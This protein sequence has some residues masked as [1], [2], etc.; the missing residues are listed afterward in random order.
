MSRPL[1]TRYAICVDLIALIMIGGC[2]APVPPSPTTPLH[3]YSS[4][5]TGMPTDPNG[6]LLETLG[7]V[8]GVRYVR[9]GGRST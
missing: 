4:N 3:L 1:R 2:V 7:A 5:D 6:F 9:V 8:D